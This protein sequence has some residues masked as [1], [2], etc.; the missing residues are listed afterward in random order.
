MSGFM[1]I[2]LILVL[3]L[4]IF[5]LPRLMS[6]NK[7][8]TTESRD[9]GFIPTGWTRLAIVV[10][11]VWL[12]VASFLLKPWNGRWDSFLYAGIGP[13]VLSWGIFWVF[14][15]FFKDKR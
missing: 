11:I 4:G 7:E 1:E 8:E 3:I 12:A 6:R 13:V 14:S 10:S 2:L 9:R 15:G 5:M